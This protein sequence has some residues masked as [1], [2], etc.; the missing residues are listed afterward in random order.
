VAAGSG[1]APLAVPVSAGGAAVAAAIVAAAGLV[2]WFRRRLRGRL[3]GRPGGGAPSRGLGWRRWSRARWLGSEPIEERHLRYALKHEQFILHY[4]PVVDVSTGSVAGLEA[5]VRWQ[6]PNGQSAPPAR[7]MSVAEASGLT[8]PLGEWVLRT[9]CSHVRSLQ[10]WRSSQ[11]RVSVNL[12]SR[13]LHDPNLASTV[14]RALEDAG[15]APEFL[16]LEVAEHDAALDVS[17]TAE[18]LEPLVALGVSITLDDFG[19]EAESKNHLEQLGV[20][21]VKVDLWEAIHSEEAQ[22]AAIEAV[23]AA[24]ALGARVTAKRVGT[25]QGIEFLAKLDVEYVQGHVFGAP[26]TAPNVSEAERHARLVAEGLSKP[27]AAA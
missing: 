25:R 11:L 27:E 8:V 12:S 1:G 15:L 10:L 14:E 4:Q 7:F 23:K 26:A 2:Y 21:S 5:L 20:R 18:A 13:Q 24:H 19:L 16:E 17:A 6:L 3:R 9:A 22:A